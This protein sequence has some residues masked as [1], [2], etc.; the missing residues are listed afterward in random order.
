MA[1]QLDGKTTKNHTEQI[2]FEI[3][4]SAEISA[5][6]FAGGA[7]D[8]ALNPEVDWLFFTMELPNAPQKRLIETIEYTKKMLLMTEEEV[9]VYADRIRKIH[10]SV[11]KRRQRREGGHPHISNQAFREVGDIIIDYGI[12]GWE[13]V[14]HRQMTATDKESY[15]QYCRRFQEYMHIKD[16]PENYQKWEIY[17]NESIENRLQKN[18]YTEKL[19]QAYKKDVGPIRFWIL[20]K[21]QARFCHPLVVQKLRLKR[22]WLIDLIMR[23]YPYIPTQ[24]DWKLAM[25]LLLKPEVRQYL[26]EFDK[27]SRQHV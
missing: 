18:E 13:Y 2:T 7:A 20:K 15:Y 5:M 11:E 26:S 16:L 3:L 14:Y 23:I 4:S 12:R 25:F 1:A 27:V 21:F 22:N 8:F 10:D 19:Y 9:K 17:R 6:L 24:L